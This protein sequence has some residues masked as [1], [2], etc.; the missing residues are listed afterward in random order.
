MS[1]ATGASLDSMGGPMAQSTLGNSAGGGG[2]S[3]A[4]MGGIVGGIMSA[5]GD[6]TQGVQQNKAYQYNADLAMQKAQET[7]AAEA[8]HQTQMERKKDAMLGTQTAQYAGRGIQ[9]DQGSPVDVMIDTAS[10]WN[11]DM[12]TSQY[13][14]EVAARGLED[15]AAMDR[16]YG[17]QAK[18]E[19]DAKGNM[20]LFSTAVDAAMLFA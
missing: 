9:A 6:Y 4:A 7:R 12:A 5:W 13:N 1:G 14:A 3:F 8:L 2:G 10:Q 18:S 20:Q 11:L 19:A 16:Y 17:R 15:Q